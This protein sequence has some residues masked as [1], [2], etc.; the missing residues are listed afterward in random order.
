MESSG[1]LCSCGA[2]KFWSSEVW[3]VKIKKG[4]HHFDVPIRPRE[5]NTSCPM[6]D[7]ASSFSQMTN[8]RS[9]KSDSPGSDP[10]KRHG[11]TYTT[12]KNSP[13][14]SPFH[15]VFVL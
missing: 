1:G 9:A 13:F 15:F 4:S 6:P 8:G 12:M 14:I 11:T 10:A 2:Q 7:D 5:L 3:V